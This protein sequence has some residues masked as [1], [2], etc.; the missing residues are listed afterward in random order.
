MSFLNGITS[1]SQLGKASDHTSNLIAKNEKF[2]K[3]ILNKGFKGFGRTGIDKALNPV[4]SF[5]EVVKEY[6]AHLSIAEIQAWVW[7]KRSIGIPMF[8]WESYYL[9]GTSEAS[10]L[11]ISKNETDIFDNSFTKIR[12]VGSGV[13]LGKYLR[14]QDQ[15]QLGKA[16]IY[17][18]E[19][20]IEMI[21]SQDAKVEKSSA[22]ADKAALLTLVKAGALFYR[23]EELLPLAIFTFGNVYDLINILKEDK[24]TIV[25]HFGI[26]AYS[27]HLSALE[28]AKPLVLSVQNPEPKERPIIT[29]ISDIASNKVEG[30][31]FTIKE[32]REEYMNVENA[33]ELR[34]VNGKVERQKKA[35]KIKI[36]FDG[37]KEYTLVDVFR[38]WLYTLNAN[39]DFKKTSAIDIAMYYIDAAPLR[40]DKLSA[41]EKAEIKTNARNEGEQL[42]AKFLH[43]VLTFADQQKLDI[44]WNKIYNGYSDINYSRVPVGFS[45]SRYFKS[46]TL[47]ITPIQREGVAFMQSVGSGV[48]AYD[49]GVGKTMTAIVNLANELQQG[50]CERPIIVVPKPTYKKWIN[51]LVGYKDAKTKAQVY[52]VLTGTGIEINDWYNLGTDIIKKID[53][54]KK[55]AKKS[56]TIVTYEGFKKIGYSDKV[57]NGLM[58]D[59]FEIL[60]SFT[61]KKSERDQAKK[62]QDVLKLLGQGNKG[63]ECD[64]DIVGFDYL[65]IDE[66]HRAKNVFAGIEADEDGNKRY[67]M[68]GGQSDTGIKAFLLSNYLQRKFGKCTMLL[69]ATPFTNSPLEI[70][71]MLSMVAY[72][73][74]VKNGLKNIKKFFDVFVL[75]TT[76]FVANYKEQIVEKEVIKSFTNRLVLQKLINNHINYKTGEEAG[77]KRPCK[78]NL[79]RINEVHQGVV[80]RLPPAQQTLTYIKMSNLQRENQNAILEM[81]ATADKRDMTIV[82]KSLGMSLDNAL[83]P[84]LYKMPKNDDAFDYKTFVNN[85]PK[86]KYVLECIKTVKEWHENRKES[87][88]G[89]VIYMNR[90]K[91]FFRY[92]KQYL[93]KEVGYKEKV[94]WKYIDERDREKT[95]ML[96]EV[97]VISSDISD[98]KK[99]AIKDAFLAGIVKIIIGTSTICEGIDLQTNGT[100]I[101]N[102]YPEWNPTQIRQLEGRIWRQGNRYGY[103]RIVM[104][105][106]Q[107]SMDVF[108]F[109]KLEEKSARINDIWF[110]GNRGNV[111]DLE[112]LDPQEVKL[113]LITDINRIVRFFFDEE[114]EKLNREFKRLKSQVDTITEV[115]QNIGKYTSLRDAINKACLNYQ[116][117][118]ENCSAILEGYIINKPEN[119]ADYPK[120]KKTVQEL[121]DDVITYN[122][123]SA[124]DDK[125]LLSILRRAD[126]LS[127]KEH[128]VYFPTIN[129][130]QINAFKELVSVIRKTERTILTPRKLTIESDFT[131]LL[132]DLNNEVAKL[133]AIANDILNNKEK[134]ELWKSIYADVQEKKSAL[135][136]EGMDATGRIAEFK[137]LNYLLAYKAEDMDGSACHI[138]SEGE[139]KNRE[140]PQP[141]DR[142]KALR[143]AKAKAKA[144]KLKLLLNI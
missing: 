138:P 103:V 137:K 38:L 104:P 44:I 100:L 110:K 36:E 125:D 116:V 123:S 107:D 34:K 9:K 33:E 71:S 15:G 117:R 55:V 113:A 30:Y 121:L 41:A 83:S 14:S 108:V 126:T 46:G 93:H 52:G 35:K 79:P 132:K 124:Q 45:C 118:L 70:Y 1:H 105:L 109:Q 90:G 133:Q 95:L 68:T 96:S 49:V 130:W 6:N 47:A 72:E 74:M 27:S 119:N 67:A 59:L 91:D 24:E 48:V 66:A 53:I 17:R 101:Y 122:T 63:T 97:E 10:E 54:T 92:M 94:E 58:T 3:S 73:Y 26:V 75:P 106:V 11:V 135:N 16:L 82:L 144:L 85:S 127:D 39:E 140:T 88:S 87:V 61:S 141:S 7:Y 131:A 136:I 112:S 25:E 20:G 43:E 21:N 40:D 37:E 77:V 50:K 23:K 4:K 32:V 31:S 134:S 56:I 18:G 78:I 81:L 80:K 42:F 129:T 2:F 5:D 13:T 115:S 128:D 12:R 64:I 69:T 84:Y 29:V 98:D 102:L 111:L 51:E 19:S 86:I 142:G 57:L 60:F 139:Y 28:K 22:T 76:E 120:R 99:E 143:L 62:K 65:V 114:K 8:G 89:Q